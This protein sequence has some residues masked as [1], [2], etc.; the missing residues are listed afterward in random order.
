MAD[1]VKLPTK[2]EI[3]KLPRWARVAFAARCARRV[4]PLFKALWPVAPPRHVFNVA[5]AVELAE[6]AAADAND[7]AAAAAAADANDDAADA[8]A[9]IRRDF[10]TLV[11]LAAGQRWTDTTP[12][13]PEV[14]GPLWPDGP[15]QGWPTESNIR[16]LILELFCRPD[17]PPEVIGEGLVKLWEAA[18]EYHMARGGGVL[19]FDD[20]KQFVGA[21]VPAGTGPSASGR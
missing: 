1:E 20:F 11:R 7:D 6:T 4:V 15:P 19:T 3:A 10:N 5:S 17:T 13:P 14:F 21:L 2:E 12:I 8:A 16:G 9:A 18:N